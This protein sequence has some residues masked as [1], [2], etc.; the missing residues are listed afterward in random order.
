MGFQFTRSLNTDVLGKYLDEQIFFKNILKDVE[1]GE[2][3]FAIRDNQITF[4]Y[5]GAQLCSIK[6]NENYTPRIN[7]AYLPI[8]RTFTNEKKYLDEKEWKEIAGTEKNFSDI[9]KEIKLIIDE[10]ERPE[11]AQISS[12]YKFSPLS[13]QTD[14]NIILLDIESAFAESSKHSSSGKKEV[15]RFDTVFFDIKEKQLI[16]IEVKRLKDNRL[17]TD[18]I[19][20]QMNSYKNL[21]KTE[22]DIIV[23]QFN[24]SIEYYNSLNKEYFEKNNKEIPMID[25]SK[26][27][28]LGLLITAFNSN[29]DKEIIRKLK[30]ERKF[31]VFQMGNLNSA[32]S[33]S[34]NNWIKNI[35]IK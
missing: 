19:H 1:R 4:Y 23:S 31:P 2:V 21:I 14:K 22:K 29:S 15:E 3:F 25:K 33:E 24:N 34:L 10:S 20:E 16:V 11:G 8:A 13:N 35:F 32:K 28:L 30:N 6:G 27:I 17:Q 9:Y 12:L 18:E 26:P 7:S 5:R